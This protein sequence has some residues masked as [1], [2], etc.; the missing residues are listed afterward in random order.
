M[1]P[2]PH[3]E[4]AGIDAD[5]DDYSW[6]ATLLQIPLIRPNRLWPGPV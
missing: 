1:R 6:L 3:N 5:A 4:P 2:V